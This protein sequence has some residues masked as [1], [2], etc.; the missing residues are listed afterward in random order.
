VAALGPAREH[1]AGDAKNLA[2]TLKLT[3]AALLKGRTRVAIL[4]LNA[5]Q[6]QLASLTLRH[7]LD[8]SIAINLGLAAETLESWLAAEK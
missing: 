5:F 6:V 3:R 4:S 2:E 7:R 1:S 8:V